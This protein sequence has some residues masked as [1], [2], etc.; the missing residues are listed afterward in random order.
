MKL[1]VKHLMKAIEKLRWEGDYSSRDGY[2]N[3]SVEI[4]TNEENVH[5]GIVCGSVTIK[6]NYEVKGDERH[7]QKNVTKSIEVYPHDENRPPV[8]T[9]VETYSVKDG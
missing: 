3:G 2:E 1:K 9:I 7:P 5:E 4:I 8:V 6:V